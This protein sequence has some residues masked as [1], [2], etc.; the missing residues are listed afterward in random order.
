MSNKYLNQYFPNTI[1]QT[2]PLGRAYKDSNDESEQ[3][4]LALSVTTILGLVLTKGAFFEMWLKNNGRHS[5]VIRDFKA[6]LG[7]VVH[8]LCEDLLNLRTVTLSTISECIQR[9]I[10]EQDLNEGGGYSAIQRSVQLYL[11][12]FMAFHEDNELELFE[13]EL[14]M[15]SPDIPYAGTADIVGRLNGKTAII[16]I[17]TGVE[18]SQHDLQLCAYGA[19]HNYLF[20][21]NKIEELYVLYLKDGYKKK[22]TYKLSKVSWDR[23]EDWKYVLRLAIS[24]HGKSGKWIFAKKYQPRKSFTLKGAK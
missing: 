3:P 5:N 10:T 23:L 19:L 22:P 21:K 2:T 7:T 20:P 13:A 16:D 24:Q 6:H 18:S 4:F 17:K 14:Q 8:V 9:F 11:E 12:S 15:F 1:R